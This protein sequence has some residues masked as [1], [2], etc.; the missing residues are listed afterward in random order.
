MAPHRGAATSAI[1]NNCT[2]GARPGQLP[3]RPAPRRC[4]PAAGCDPRR[5]S[6]QRPPGPRTLRRLC[7]AAGTGTVVGRT[8]GVRA[9]GRRKAAP[10]NAGWAPPG[11]RAVTEARPGFPDYHPPCADALT[12]PAGQSAN[13]PR[14]A[15]VAGAVVLL[16]TTPC[17]GEAPARRTGPRGLLYTGPARRQPSH[18]TC[19]LPSITVFHHHHIH[20]I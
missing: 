18:D 19:L 7:T 1:K 6:V 8:G 14:A 9:A 17:L 2:Y 5:P 13:L 20:Y 12:L 4:F 15:C 3:V 10:C 11:A 16:H